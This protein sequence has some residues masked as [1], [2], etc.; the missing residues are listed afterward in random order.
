MSNT[1]CRLHEGLPTWRISDWLLTEVS[2]NLYIAVFYIFKVFMHKKL[3]R[4]LRNQVQGVDAG[5][6]FVFFSADCGLCFA[7]LSALLQLCLTLGLSCFSTSSCGLSPVLFIF[8]SV[9]FN[10]LPK[11]SS[12]LCYSHACQLLYSFPF[13]TCLEMPLSWCKQ[14]VSIQ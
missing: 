4:L 8:S 1:M 2:P 13:L 5:Q 14:L 7:L 10:V 6:D 3:P 12:A 11:S 9:H